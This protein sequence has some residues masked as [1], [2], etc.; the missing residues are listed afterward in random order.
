MATNVIVLDNNT[1]YKSSIV[2]VLLFY[3][4]SY[5]CILNTHGT[6]FECTVPFTCNM[7]TTAMKGFQ[8][9]YAKEEKREMKVER[10]DIVWVR[11]NGK[12]DV[13][14]DGV[15][16]MP[17][18]N[19]FPTVLVHYF[20]MPPFSLMV[21]TRNG[22]YQLGSGYTGK[23]Y[24]DFINIQKQFL[25]DGIVEVHLGDVWSNVPW[26]LLF[27]FLA[28]ITPV[29]L[30]STRIEYCS[31]KNI[32]TEYTYSLYRKSSIRYRLPTNKEGAILIGAKKRKNNNTAIHY[33]TLRV[34][35]VDHKVPTGLYG[36][37]R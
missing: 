1:L 7:D 30:S 20:A 34:Y 8:K 6:H 9:W 14:P 5:L 32:L 10:M 3:I 26:C 16:F 11:K 13:V 25:K 12:L 35:D 15:E 17:M 18:R 33:V 37:L 36:M 22:I 27:L 29:Q 28:I 19:V 2:L 23:Q 4:L 21:K 24:R 31:K